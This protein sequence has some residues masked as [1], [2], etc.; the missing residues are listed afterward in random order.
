MGPQQH[1]NQSRSQSQ[2][3]VG[4]YNRRHT[5][6]TGHIKPL[7]LAL[8]PIFGLEKSDLSYWDLE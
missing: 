8:L 4:H 3:V 2:N 5:N 6:L 7:F 1:K